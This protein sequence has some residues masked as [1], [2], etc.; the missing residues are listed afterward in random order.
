MGQTDSR[1]SR[2]PARRHRSAGS[3]PVHAR[4]ELHHRTDHL[5]RRRHGQSPRRHSPLSRSRTAG[6]ICP[7][8]DR[9]GLRP[10][11]AL[12]VE[13]RR[14][15]KEEGCLPTRGVPLWVYLN[16]TGSSQPPLILT[17]ERS[18][19]PKRRSIQSMRILTT[20]PRSRRALLAAGGAAL[21]GSASLGLLSLGAASA[22]PELAASP[23]P[24][25][26]AAPVAAPGA[27]VDVA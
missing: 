27:L 7:A 15:L 8:D 1:G 25:A 24:A 10:T 2:R 21:I 3:V 13:C 16:F 23:S 4:G 26:P 19:K 20:V 18:Y 11:A 12:R 22:A 17:L 14:S 6:A 9:W 5:G